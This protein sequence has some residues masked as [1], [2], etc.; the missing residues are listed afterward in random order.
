LQEWERGIKEKDGEGEFSFD[1]CMTYC[2][3]HNASQAST[4]KF[5]NG[6]KRR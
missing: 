1:I 5:K 6:Q 4:I 2:K 3:Y